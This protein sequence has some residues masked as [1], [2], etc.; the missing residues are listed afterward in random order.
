MVSLADERYVDE[1]LEERIVLHGR[2]KSSFP[3][4]AASAAA[5]ALVL[6]GIWHFANTAGLSPEDGTPVTHSAADTV[7]TAEEEQTFDYEVLFK[8]KYSGELPIS[9][10]VFNSKT[11]NKGSLA[12]DGEYALS[13]LPFKAEG[14]WEKR[15]QFYL[16]PDE[17]GEIFGG[18]IY[19]ES[20][21]DETASPKFK[22]IN[23]NMGRDG[24]LSHSFPIEDTVPALR[25]GTA[26]YCYDDT[27]AYL[28]DVYS[29]N[30]KAYFVIGDMEYAVETC[31]ISAAETGEIIDSIID[32]GLS[33]DSFDISRAYGFEDITAEISYDRANATEPFTGYVPVVDGILYLYTDS[34]TYDVQKVNGEVTGQYMAVVYTDNTDDGERIKFD[35]YTTGYFGR[36][37]FENTADLYDI[38][39]E[40]IDAFMTDGE[41]KF[42]ADCG[43]FMINVTAK[44]SADKLMK[45]I[46][47]IR[48]GTYNAGSDITLAEAIRD[49]VTSGLVPPTE[50]I[51]TMSLENG[52]C[53]LWDNDGGRCIKVKYT[54]PFFD[55]D[56]ERFE[57]YGKY[58]TAS[59]SVYDGSDPDARSLDEEITPWFE[60]N[61]NGVAKFGFSV[62]SG[63]TRIRVQALCTN[64]EMA[65]FLMYVR[66]FSRIDDRFY[67]EAEQERRSAERAEQKR[68][69]AETEKVDFTE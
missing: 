31:N 21:F 2:K 56:D 23:I 24:T 38:A 7:F 32:S 29:S 48:G 20:E 53:K 55:Y 36:E 50:R 35:Y 69:A 6:G 9:F 47:A 52:V 10:N 57:E 51:G 54:D 59:Y 22:C 61:D 46:D 49:P 41:Y 65:E 11:R 13:I 40:G 19:L 27:G 28:S 58:L 39:P 44:C 64:E 62:Y 67:D 30:L 4:L 34:V 15:N 42:T 12:F 17:N 66:E 3:A 63:S 1:M 25:F 45:Y 18:I 33:P 26:L 14:F 8:N 43:K 37:P 60:L 5:M 68:I 16:Y